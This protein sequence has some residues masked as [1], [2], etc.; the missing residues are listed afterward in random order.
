MSRL[1]LVRARLQVLDPLQFQLIDDSAAHTGHLGA[2]DGG[3]FRLSIVSA[4]FSG[5]NTV[6]RHRMVYSAL[7]DLMQ[8]G[9]HALTIVALAPE[10]LNSP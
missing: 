9:I 8:D 3:H 7:Q 10:E 2:R 4:A 5:K 1:E 6:T